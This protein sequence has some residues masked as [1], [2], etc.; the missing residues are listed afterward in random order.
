MAMNRGGWLW[1]RVGSNRWDRWPW[2]GVDH[3]GQGWMAKDGGEWLWTW[4]ECYGWG[5][6]GRAWVCMAMNECG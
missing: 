1:T 5:L 2:L 4:V 6:N 3:H